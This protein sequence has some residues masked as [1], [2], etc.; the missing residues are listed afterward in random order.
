[1]IVTFLGYGS[2][3]FP[4]SFTGLAQGVYTNDCSRSIK[5]NTLAVRSDL[6]SHPSTFKELFFTIYIYIIILYYY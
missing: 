6:F 5:E 4:P 1:M 3:T 2:T